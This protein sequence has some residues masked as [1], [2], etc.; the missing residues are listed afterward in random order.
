MVFKKKPPE[1]HI[2]EG[3]IYAQAVSERL[4]SIKDLEEIFKKGFVLIDSLKADN[5][6]W[7]T[8]VKAQAPNQQAQKTFKV[9]VDVPAN[10]Q[11]EADT[12]INQQLQK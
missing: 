6:Y 2:D 3:E 1:L 9:S 5:K 7:F 11:E 12:I 10:T 4:L 8:F